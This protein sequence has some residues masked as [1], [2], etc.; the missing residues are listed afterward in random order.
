MDATTTSVNQL[1]ICAG[2]GTQVPIAESFYVDGA[3]QLCTTNCSP[4]IPVDLG[5]IEPPF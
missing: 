2:C 4:S 1:I 5:D 3:G